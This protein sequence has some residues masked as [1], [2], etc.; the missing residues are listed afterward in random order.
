DGERLAASDQIDVSVTV[1]IPGFVVVVVAT[2]R[3]HAL[4]R[5]QPGAIS[6]EQHAGGTAVKNVDEMVVIQIGGAQPKWPRRNRVWRAHVGGRKLH[7]ASR[8][9][10]ERDEGGLA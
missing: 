10:E 3:Q 6:E 4:G 5:E 2:R 7:K 8:L 9:G 1:D